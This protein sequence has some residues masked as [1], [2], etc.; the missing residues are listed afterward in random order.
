L[1]FSLGV[2]FKPKLTRKASRK[3]SDAI[4]ADSSF[5]V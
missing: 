4:D 5:T 2:D 1:L 3:W